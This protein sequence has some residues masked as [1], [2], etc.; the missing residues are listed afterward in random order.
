[1]INS[2]I[3]HIPDE[4]VIV[5][6]D[7][8]SS[9]KY[10][11]DILANAGYRTRSAND[12]ELALRSIQAKL[13]DIILLDIKLPG[14]S[15]IEICRILKADPKTSEVPIIFISAL[16]ETELKVKALEAGGIDYVTKPIEPSEVLT[17][18]NTHL[19]IYRL[20]QRL[21]AKSEKLKQ[22]IEDHKLSDAKLNESRK[23]FRLAFENANI[24]MCVIDLNGQLLQVNDQMCSIFGYSKDELSGL[25]IKKL[26]HP[27][28]FG[29]SPNFMQI[30][31]TDEINHGL[32]KKRYLHKKGK[33][34]WGDVSSS[35]VRD[36]EGNPLYF[37]SHFQDITQQRQSEKD[38]VEREKRL[39]AFINSS[40]DYINI[41]NADL[42]CIDINNTLL[43]RFKR[44]REDL[45]G[46]TLEELVPGI[47]K[48][49]RYEK[50]MHVLK[51]GESLV[52]EE[53]L[54]FEDIAVGEIKLLVK[55]IK[56]GEGLAIITSDV[57][58]RVAVEQKLQNAHDELD[59]KVQDR[60]QALVE[61]NKQL[62]S[63]IN[64]R[65]QINQKLQ[66][67]QLRYQTV[68]DF[69]YN[70]ET[71]VDPNGYYIYVS[72][73]CERIS[74][75]K[76]EE[77]IKNPDLM[78]NITHPE[79]QAHI[80]SHFK[81]RELLISPM[82]PID[83]RIIKKNG[84]VIW[85]NHVC[86]HVHDA[87]GN[88]LGRR[89]SNQEITER[90][91][92]QNK[93]EKYTKTQV[94]LY[95]EVNHR[96][97]NNLMALTGMLH[98]EAEI[99]KK[100]KP[101]TFTPVIKKLTGRI[102]SLSIVHNLLSKNYWRSIKLCD[103]C[104]EI[105]NGISGTSIK[106]KKKSINITP[107]SIKINSAEAH[108][109]SLVFNELISNSVK[110]ANSN[111]EKTKINIDIQGQSNQIIVQFCDNGQGYPDDILSQK[112]SSLGSGLTLINGLINHSLLGEVQYE[113]KNGA[114][115]RISF[116][117]QSDSSDLQFH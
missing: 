55:A 102:E 76:P 83:F 89:G 54:D 24:G 11:T 97:K 79:D 61:T 28:D 71:W 27:D 6:E 51:T 78:I 59:Q 56:V 94:I 86:R 84:A 16:S 43:E 72:P 80:H 108:H 2:K 22:E 70:W 116:E 44:N 95:K 7:N 31:E 65:K 12:G 77:F 112:Q 35:L 96:V 67:S 49:G 40:P 50:Y 26:T 88:F 74:G 109:L 46:K 25:N 33:L 34:I 99:I 107:S 36:E 15:G 92:N 5:V 100:R 69:N 111:S 110:Y 47:K 60:T 87:D 73:S 68:A 113:N 45:V 9:L 3:N 105:V 30:A 20:Q 117:K 63:E 115:A 64:E 81:K 19:S 114:V 75:Y 37:I 66:E 29:K 39:T 10:L 93:L 58:E 23:R 8:V 21:R 42:V 13:P 82:Q 101:K 103:L 53:A 32:F 1:M 104:Q 18:I 85:I 38:L 106:L 52:I 48:S 57:T 17:R 98:E 91:N 14:T 4:E 90:I 62:S 41:F